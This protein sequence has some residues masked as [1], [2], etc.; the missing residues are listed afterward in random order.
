LRR[1]GRSEFSSD[2]PNYDRSNTSVVVENIPEENFTEDAV[3]TFFAQFGKVLEVDMRPY[4]RLAIIK[5]ED[6]D[7]AKAAHTSPKVVF[8]NR[9]VKVYWFVDQESLPQP[10]ASGVN[11]TA[12]NGSKTATPVPAR[13]TTEPQID[14]VEFGKRQEEAQK[15]HEEK[16]RKA[17]EMEVAKK[18]LEK[19]QI[20]LL[21]RQAEAKKQLMA[22][23]A[24]KK[25][26]RKSATPPIKTEDSSPAP[27]S[28][29]KSNPQTE[30]LKAQLAALEAEAH[31]LGI[32]PSQADE[33]SWAG[34]GRGRG[35]GIYRGRGAFAPRGFR[36][37]YRGRGGPPFAAG[38]RS[39]NL[40][41]RTKKVGL[42]GV[43]FS[44][45]EKDESLR[46]YLLVSLYLF[47]YLRNS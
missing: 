47:T 3:R 41:N 44:D 45:P 20:I 2:R 8:D 12:K 32:D 16:A 19:R 24:A 7:M 13:L 30:A 6:Y 14:I 26:I 29:S 42:T 40:D 11:A 4:K 43:D 17:A 39:F 38:G 5:F 18:E 21:E 37:G 27:Q 15:L 46:Q 33:P 31:S 25:G 22:R 28:Q 36:G 1:G 34:R 35:R 10:R 9:F 23:I